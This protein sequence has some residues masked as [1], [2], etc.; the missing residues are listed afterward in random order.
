MRS[1]FTSINL[2]LFL[3]DQN[4]IFYLFTYKQ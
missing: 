1:S 4:V 3:H 2:L